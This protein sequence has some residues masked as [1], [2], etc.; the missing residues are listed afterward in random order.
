MKLRRFL[1]VT[2]I[3][4]G[5][6]AA[7]IAAQG[8]STSSSGVSGAG[9][10]AGLHPPVAPA[11]AAA[12]TLGTP[13][14]FA[15]QQ[16]FLGGTKRDG[17]P[18]D[19]AWKDYGYDL[20][21]KIT[22]AKST[23]VCTL[24]DG[25]QKAAQ[26]DGTQGTDNAFGET[27]LPIITSVAPTAETDISK[28][29]TDGSFTIMLDIQGL[30]DDTAQNNTTL[31]GQIFAG[32][33]YSTDKTMHPAF[34]LTTDWPVRPELLKDGKTIAGG[35]S[36]QFDPASTYV[37]A[38]QF[39]TQADIKLSLAVGGVGLDLVIHKAIITFT[40]SDPHTANIGTIAGIIQTEELISG[41]KRVAGRIQKSLCEGAA[42]DQIAQEIRQASD[43]MSDGTNVAGPKCDGIS[44]GLGF[45]AKEIKHPTKVADLA[46]PSPDPCLTPADA[47]TT[48]DSGSTDQ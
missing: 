13:R 11:N 18:S 27:I 38:G 19:S 36:V 26:T 5:V 42:F 43:I 48:M 37:V 41:L 29:L 44:I 17:S 30:T 4:T 45:V 12:A 25:A 40:H 35:S 46:A 34:D 16:L 31:S 33:A 32:G 15:L 8:C 20:D 1:P 22:S 47:G 28:A 7:T 6:I 14:T 21:G 23:D 2:A 39:V 3:A 24:A 10:G 9:G